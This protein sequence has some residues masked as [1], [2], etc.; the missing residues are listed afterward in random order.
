MLSWS[1]VRFMGMLIDGVV[2]LAR[3]KML[4]WRSIVWSHLVGYRRAIERERGFPSSWGSTGYRS[5]GIADLKF[6]CLRWPS[7]THLGWR[8]Q[9]ITQNKHTVRAGRLSKYSLHVSPRHE[10]GEDRTTWRQDQHY[11][12]GEVPVAE[13]TAADLSKFMA[14]QTSDRLGGPGVKDWLPCPLLHF[15]WF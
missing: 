7:R 4:R 1:S 11:A 8:R 15:P 5:H 13:R 14:G 12:R 3:R 10:P 9:R 6:G 2:G